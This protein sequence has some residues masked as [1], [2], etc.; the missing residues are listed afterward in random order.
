MAQRTYTGLKPELFAKHLLERNHPPG[1]LEQTMSILHTTKK[2]RM[3]NTI[4]KYYIHEDTYYDNQLNDR[5][6][7]TPNIIFDTVLHNKSPTVNSVSLSFT[8]DVCQPPHRTHHKKKT[9]GLQQCIL[10]SHQNQKQTVTF[11]SK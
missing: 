9:S 6:T 5:A 11:Q 1:T 10:S 4:E 8:P 7:V 2:G 3:L